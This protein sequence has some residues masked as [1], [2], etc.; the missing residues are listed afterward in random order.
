MKNLKKLAVVASVIGMI[1]VSSAAYAATVKT[2]A[3]IASGLTGKTVQ[4][5]YGERV[6]GK[7]Y[8]TM[9]QEAGKLDEFKTQMLEQKKAILD[10]RVKDGELTQ[11]QADEI[12]SAIESNQANCDGTGN[13]ALGKNYG[14]GF[15]QGNGMNR[16]QGAGMRDGTCTGMGLGNGRNINK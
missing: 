15:G 2:P 12:Y 4:E 3:D 8:G 9:A 14:A 13:A 5:L 6:S 1:A 7:T 11:V 16:G 10:Q